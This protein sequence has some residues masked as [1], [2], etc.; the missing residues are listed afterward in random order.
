MKTRRL[1]QTS[2][3]WVSEHALFTPPLLGASPSGAGS[4]IPKNRAAQSLA[5][6][7]HL[8]GLKFRSDA[9]IRCE[10]PVCRAPTSSFLPL[11]PATVIITPSPQG[12]SHLKHKRLTL[13]VS[14]LVSCPHQTVSLGLNIICTVVQRNATDRADE[15]IA[16]Q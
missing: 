11:K 14:K 10:S 5:L 12:F 16:P 13:Y 8:T 1:R 7:P 6:L 9:T 2:Q 3:L 4:A 15:E